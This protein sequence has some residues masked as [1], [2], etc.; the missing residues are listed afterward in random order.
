M[1][2]NLNDYRYEKKFLINY[3]NIY[4]IKNIIKIN[5]NCFKTIY[6]K[7]NVN[8]IYFDYP[9]LKC[10][11]DSVE[12]IANRY[13]IRIRWYGDLFG[14]AKNP[15]L[16]IKIKKNLIS[17]KIKLPI[18]EFHFNSDTKINEI[19]DI[20][21]NAIKKYILNWKLLSKTLINTYERDYFIS[22]DKKF[23]LTLD[24]KQS[25][26][27]C[28]NFKNLLKNEVKLHNDYILEIKYDCK[29]SLNSSSIENSFGLRLTKNS[30]YVV[31]LNAVN[32]I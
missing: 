19:L 14:L 15:N 30:K 13:K 6:K 25:F 29:N 21:K 26:Y 22:F 7:R 8:N 11:S 5:N 9:N 18:E 20:N 24:S 10:Y 27:N 32:I 31:G 23:N 2:T 3:L 16:E 28:L 4:Q 1:N 12:G 17:T